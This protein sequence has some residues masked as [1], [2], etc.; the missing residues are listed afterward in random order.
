[1]HLI[2]G[3]VIFGFLVIG[4]ITGFIV[5]GFRQ[6]QGYGRAGNAM[7]GTVGAIIGGAIYDLS[8]IDNFFTLGW[9]QLAE[10]MIFSLAGAA[11]TLFVADLVRK[12]E[13]F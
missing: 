10:L 7:I 6:R 1:M 13:K 11:V 9:P 12:R 5:G 8:G 4:V 2:D 3:T